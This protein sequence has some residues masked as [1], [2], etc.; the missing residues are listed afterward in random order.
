MRA[1]LWFMLL[2]LAG[3]CAS[4]ED[5]PTTVHDLRVLGITFDPP[6]VMAPS[7]DVQNP[8]ANL[9]PLLS[10]T[11]TMRALI[12][13]PAGEGRDISY[14][15]R[16]CAWPGDR[17]CDAEFDSLALKKTDGSLA[18]GTV[19]DGEELSLTFSPASLFLEKR[20]VDNG[21]GTTRPQHLLEQVL[22]QDVYKGL[23]GLRMPVMLHLKA[24]DE[25][26]YAQKLMVFSCKLQFE[27]FEEMRP[28]VQPVL[29]GVVL[30]GEP[31]PQTPIRSVQGSGPFKVTPEDFSGLQEAYVVP[32]F[33]LKP[34]HLDESWKISWYTTYGRMSA[35]NSGGTDPDGETGRH[36]LEWTPPTVKE[37]KQVSFYIVVR[38][39]RGGTSWIT[40]RVDYAP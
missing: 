39:G 4:P 25:E 1:A 5:N 35:E 3:A 11:I 37:A 19:K 20:T 34:V 22:A 38:D 14:D 17:E 28:N 26:I 6:E 30:E 33:E 21:D 40:R 18:E 32:S 29:P 23:G 10:T 24:G 15:V 27:G 9:L 36:N 13:D 31:W 7:C 2:L 16:A 12:A 8:A